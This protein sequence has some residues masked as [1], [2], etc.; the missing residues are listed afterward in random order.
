MGGLELREQRGERRGVQIGEQRGLQMG[1]LQEKRELVARQL[2]RKFHPLPESVVGMLEAIPAERLDEIALNLIDA[3][4]LEE[5]G[6]VD[7]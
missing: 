7:T 2:A 1:R 3:K 5:L 6:L 4:S